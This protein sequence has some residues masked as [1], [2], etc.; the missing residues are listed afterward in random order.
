MADE[1]RQWKAKFDDLQVRSAQENQQL[2]AGFDGL[3]AKLAQ[4]ADRRQGLEAERANEAAN[5]QRLEREVQQLRAQLA[6]EAADKQH[7][8]GQMAELTTGQGQLRACT[9]RLKPP[10]SF[11]S[12]DGGHL[13]HSRQQVALVMVWCQA[14]LSMRQA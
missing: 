13:L 9:R 5:R 6:N 10:P 14:L 1:R 2:R 8:A 3:E 12:S 7:L 11:P 4:E